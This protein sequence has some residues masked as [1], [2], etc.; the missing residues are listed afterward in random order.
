MKGIGYM[1]GFLIITLLI[2]VGIVMPFFLL[3]VHIQRLVIYDVDYNNGQ[4]ILLSLLSSTQTDPLDGKSK[5]VYEIIAESMALNRPLD[6]SLKL[7]GLVK[8]KSYKLYYIENG[9]EISLGQS[10]DPSRFK[11]NTKIILPYN[12]DNLFKKL[13]LVID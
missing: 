12:S 5:P 13:T 7:D 8:G 10:G 3:Q 6:L 11:V 2:M 9:Q 4:L 1:F